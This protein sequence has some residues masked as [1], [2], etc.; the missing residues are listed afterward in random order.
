MGNSLDRTI[1]DWRQHAKD[2]AIWNIEKGQQLT[3]DDIY[4]AELART[5]IYAGTA[6]FFQTYDAVLTP[7][8]QV[9]PFDAEQEWVT[10]VDGQTMDTYIDWM[11]ICCAITVTG[12]PAISVPGGFTPAGLPVGIQL[13]GKPRGD[14]AL[15]QLAHCFE[16]A[17]QHYLTKPTVHAWPD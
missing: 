5:Q 9:A 11:T 17:T 3:A 2:T 8:A 15:L 6:E 4:Q 12:C 16:Q 13:V 14:L 7:A 1:P 10:E